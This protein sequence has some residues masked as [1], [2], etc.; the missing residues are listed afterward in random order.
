MCVILYL[1]PGSDKKAPFLEEAITKASEF[2][3]DGMGY[4]IKRRDNSIYLSKGFFE[5]E[6]F[7]KSIKD[8]KVLKNEELLIHL[9]I[10][11]VGKVNA[12]MCHPF[13]V[14]A[15][16]DEITETIEGYMDKPVMA[17]NGTMLKHKYLKSALSDTVY[18][19]KDVLSYESVQN[20]LKEDEAVFEEV[21]ANHLNNSRIAIMY[22]D[23][24]KT[25]LLGEWHEKE[26]I[27]FSKD[28]QKEYVDVVKRVY[29]SVGQSYDYYDDYYNDLFTESDP[30]K[31]EYGKSISLYNKKSFK[32]VQS[33]LSSLVKNVNMR[34]V[35]TGSTG[36][37]YTKYMGFFL[38]EVLDSAYKLYNINVDNE[39]VSEVDISCVKRDIING[40]SPG[41]SYYLDE[42]DDSNIGVVN[43]KTFEITYITKHS[44]YEN[45]IH[46]PA[47]KS[48][49]FFDDL[50]SLVVSTPI[51]R[52]M[53]KK[54][55]KNYNRSISNG[56][57]FVGF[58]GKIIDV[59]IAARFIQL[60]DEEIEFI[61]DPKTLLF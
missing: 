40:L 15:V 17:H 21:M 41:N 16:Q 18:F 52:N 6:E 29:G 2:N 37:K 45:F 31:N 56:K 44:F 57:R 39:V 13:V 46:W 10:G 48:R 26:G 50:Y 30:P 53:V 19:I 7:I 22:P 34:E 35:Y 1:K 60:A 61:K 23:S 54:L 36:I 28:Y 5:V 51:T 11:N 14:S 3:K 9:R 43:S 58:R 27:L 38:P 59:K 20:F 42:A 25:N 24:S 4:A 33:N 47:T 55:K 8:A 32:N 49:T 12:G